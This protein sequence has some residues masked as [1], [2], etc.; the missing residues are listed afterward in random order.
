MKRTIASASA[1]AFLLALFSL[2]LLAEDKAA[3]QKGEPKSPQE[4]CLA[5]S[6]KTFEA[7]KAECAKDLNLQV[8]CD[9][10]CSQKNND[11]EKVCKQP[12]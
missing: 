3:P 6:A 10:K 12:T 4:R 7:C 1:I 9:A 11:R 5:Q 8:R 2:P